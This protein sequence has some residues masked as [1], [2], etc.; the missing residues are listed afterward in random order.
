[1]YKEPHKIMDTA[2]IIISSL[3]KQFFFLRYDFTASIINKIIET[4]TA[5]IAANVQKDLTLKS[6]ISFFERIFSTINC[7]RPTQITEIGIKLINN[8]FLLNFKMK[9]PILSLFCNFFCNKLIHDFSKL[10]KLL[11]SITISAFKT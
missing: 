4:A 7:T 9:S 3:L 6:S 8:L 1:M 5:I 11:L 10:C 2:V